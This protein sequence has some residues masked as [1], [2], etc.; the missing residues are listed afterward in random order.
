M[1]LDNE[2]ER[3]EE[4]LS[5]LIQSSPEMV[6]RKQIEKIKAKKHKNLVK[7]A[8][9]SIKGNK[10][11]IARELKKYDDIKLRMSDMRESIKALDD[12]AKVSRVKQGELGA[13]QAELVRQLKQLDNPVP[14]RE[15]KPD[16]LGIYEE[17]VE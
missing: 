1:S 16:K 2:L 4:E 6:L 8:Q 15:K 10:G 7:Q 5:A 17:T 12:E 14:V 13:T 9:S 11:A 3:K